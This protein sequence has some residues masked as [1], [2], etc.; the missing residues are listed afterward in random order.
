MN[1]NLTTNASNE[2]ESPAFLVGAVSGSI[3]LTAKVPPQ[4]SQAV[5]ELHEQYNV[6][7]IGTFDLDEKGFRD[8]KWKKVVVTGREE[9]LIKLNKHCEKLA[10]GDV[11]YCH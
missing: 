10:Y 1:D 4:F 8:D 9:D 11:P 7:L 3:T 2:A 6:K 5:V